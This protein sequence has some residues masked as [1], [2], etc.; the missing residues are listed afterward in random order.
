M[1]ELIDDNGKI[2]KHASTS[3]VFKKRLAKDSSY[4][5]DETRGNFEKLFKH[6]KEKID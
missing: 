5:T 3:A 4:I 6:L 1:S 2:C